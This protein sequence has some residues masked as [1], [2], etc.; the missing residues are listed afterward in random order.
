MSN[1]QSWQDFNRVIR[2]FARIQ[3]SIEDVSRWAGNLQAIKAEI[4]DAAERKVE[5]KKIIDIHPDYT[6][7]GV[8]AMYQKLQTLKTYLE[9]NGYV[10]IEEAK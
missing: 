6:I 9:N 10:T 2:E 8:V 1:Q 3:E 7:T 4:F 5:L